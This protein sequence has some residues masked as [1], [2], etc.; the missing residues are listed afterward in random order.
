MGKS[1]H[2][3]I[4]QHWKAK[5]ADGKLVLYSCFIIS[6]LSNGDD[7]IFFSG[8]I[9]FVMFDIKTNQ[10]NRLITNCAVKTKVEKPHN[11]KTEKIAYFVVPSNIQLFQPKKK[12][13]NSTGWSSFSFCFSFV[14][15]E[16]GG[17][18]IHFSNNS[19]HFQIKQ[20]QLFTLF[21]ITM[22]NFK[23]PTFT[24]QLTFLPPVL[25]EKGRPL[26]IYRHPFVQF[27]S[28]LMNI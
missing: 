4:V 16:M 2:L 15:T 24:S 19:L 5:H 25:C 10:F 17:K 8:M 3:K 27:N 1:F 18:K 6:H 13:F 11:W 9:Q 28:L 14:W 12:L 20:L 22:N 26:G 21:D 23:Q 7:T